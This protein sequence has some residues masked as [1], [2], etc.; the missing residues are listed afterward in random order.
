MDGWA[1]HAAS[2]TWIELRRPAAG[3]AEMGQAAVW[4][5]DRLF[6]FGGSR[7]A[8]ERFVLVGAGWSWVPP[9]Q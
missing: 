5:E 3:A 4:T 8:D 9:R 7:V 6:V 2:G 1:F